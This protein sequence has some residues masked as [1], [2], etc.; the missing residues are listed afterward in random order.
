MDVVRRYGRVGFALLS[1]ILWGIVTY[2]RTT[3]HHLKPMFRLVLMTAV[4]PLLLTA[5]FFPSTVGPFAKKK[6]D[7]PEG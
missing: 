7:R 1:F 4:V 2:D 3:G 6:D 5:M